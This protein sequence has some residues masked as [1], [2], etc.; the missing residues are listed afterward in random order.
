LLLAFLG[1]ARLE[2]C[3]ASWELRFVGDSLEAMF[4]EQVV[5]RFGQQYLVGRI[6]VGRQP[7]QHSDDLGV[8]I[9]A[10]LPAACPRFSALSHRC[11]I[12]EME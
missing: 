6:A 5:Q 8:E 1:T 2:G 4:L 3:A 11:P 9:A 12:Q 10:Y 7:S